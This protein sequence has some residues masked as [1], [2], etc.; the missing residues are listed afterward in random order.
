[1]KSKIVR[2]RNGCVTCKQR[3]R[4]CDETKPVCLNCTTSGRTCGGYVRQFIFDVDDSRKKLSHHGYAFK[5]RPRKIK[6]EIVHEVEMKRESNSPELIFKFEQINNNNGET[7]AMTRES[8]HTSD[9]FDFG[10][11]NQFELA[12]F[13]GLDYIL[14][15]YDTDLVNNIDNISP[16]TFI[17]QDYNDVP[18]L[19][20]QEES[21][22]LEHFFSKVMYLLDAHPQNPWPQLMMKFGSV[23]LAKSCFLSLSSMHLY[24]NNGGDNFYKK[25]LMHINNTMEYLIKYVK[26]SD[27]EID[28]PGVISKIKQ[29]SVKQVDKDKNFMVVL[30]LLYV[31]LLFAILESGRSALSRMFL[32]LAASIAEDPI[33]NRKLKRIK[34]S[35]YLLCVISWWDTVSALVSPDCR[36]PY[37]S[38]NSFGNSN[39]IISTDNMC[40]CPVA[41]FSTLY[42]LALFRNEALSTFTNQTVPI[43]SITTLYGKLI[44]IRSRLLHYRDHVLLNPP[45]ESAF[46]YVDRL[47]CAQLWSIAGMLLTVQL[48]THYFEQYPSW[49]KQRRVALNASELPASVPASLHYN[50]HTAALVAEFFALHGTL[51]PTSPLITQMV[52]PLFYAAAC[53]YTVEARET[54]WAQLQT[55]YETVKMGTIKSN[56]EVV[57]Q[58]WSEGCSIESILAGSGWLQNG[59]DLLPC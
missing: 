34:Q 4:K 30:L 14:D 56:M 2:S 26:S 59:I 53:A 37:H 42:D 57:R 11:E 32:K 22:I 44:D 9:E 48:E 15:N 21:H 54:A 17:P 38:I 1:M 8:T 7:V 5:G 39:D 19:K 16:P 49:V 51:S 25:G 43:T 40:G 28:I 47:K 13:S 10:D 29:E 23:D 36:P 55:L 6:E 33:F 46:K 3:R 20:K 52:W 50:N 45:T 18:K 12:L 31:H 35:Q 24:V 58:V 27:S 41:T